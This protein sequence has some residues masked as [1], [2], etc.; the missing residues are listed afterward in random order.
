MGSPGQDDG[1]ND[2]MART[3]KVAVVSI[4][5]RLAPENPYP[6]QVDDCETILTWLLKNSRAEFG[7]DKIIL[8]GESAGSQLAVVTLIRLRNKQADIKNVIGLSLFYG[9]YDISGTPS[10][11]QSTASITLRKKERTQVLEKVFP[12]KSPEELRDSS[13]SP[14]FASLNGLPPAIFS[15]GALDPLID[16]SKFMAARWESAGNQT[17]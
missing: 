16:D 1:Q 2:L 5:Y 3:C 10:N 17:I 15:V 7:T 11:R 14:L 4:D 6:A 12:G 8:S 9:C 13:L